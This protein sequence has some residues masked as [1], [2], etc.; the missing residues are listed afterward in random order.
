MFSKSTTKVSDRITVT[1]LI[2]MYG[3]GLVNATADV[4]GDGSEAHSNYQCKG[5]L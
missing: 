3:V 2:G 1:A 4:V 5:D